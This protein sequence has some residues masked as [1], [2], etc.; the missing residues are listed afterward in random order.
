[1]WV[2]S[3]WKTRVRR[4]VLLNIKYVCNNLKLICC[5]SYAKISFCHA[6]N[7]WTRRRTTEALQ[8]VYVPHKTVVDEICWIC[9]KVDGSRHGGTSST[10][11]MAGRRHRCIG[12]CAFRGATR[13]RGEGQTTCACQ[14]CTPQCMI[15]RAK[16]HGRWGAPIAVRALRSP[17]D[18]KWRWTEVCWEGVYMAQG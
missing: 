7:C 13:F 3:S 12:L 1:M 17:L 10:S 5:E 6:S 14:L 11:K 4:F 15:R 18:H 2:D 8:P 16:V 9:E